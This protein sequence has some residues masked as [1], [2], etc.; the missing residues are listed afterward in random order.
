MTEKYD[1]LA[2]LYREVESGAFDALYEVANME[3]PEIVTGS[4]PV[5]DPETARQY[6]AYVKS[7]L[8]AQI[9]Q[10]DDEDLLAA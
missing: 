5:P 4:I 9:I 2:E 1:P 7:V 6:A 3:M 8:E 10:A